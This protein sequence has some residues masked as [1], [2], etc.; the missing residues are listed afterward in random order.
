MGH[1]R[2]DEATLAVCSLAESVRFP[3]HAEPTQ[4]TPLWVAAE[5]QGLRT[6]SYFWVGSEA[7]IHGMRPSAFFPYNGTVTHAQRIE[8][9]L[10]WF[11][12]PEAS[13]PHL[14]TLYFSD[15][16]SAGH[17]FGAD[18]DEVKAA[19]HAA[20]ESIGRLM[21]GLTGVTP[22]PN[23]VI[24]AD[25]GMSTVSGVI[26]ITDDVDLSGFRVVNESTHL[27]IYSKDPA[28]V[29]AALESLNKKGRHYQA[30]RRE[31]VPAHLHFSRNAR[32]GDI[33]VIP[34][35]AQFVIA[36]TPEVR[37]PQGLPKGWH[38]WDVRAV[39]DM[40]GLFCA[41]GPGIRRIEKLEPGDIDNVDV[42]PMVLR[43][44][45]L[46]VPAD[47]DGSMNLAGRILK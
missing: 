9:V 10:E 4:G 18:S 19:V 3:F 39:P 1:I 2:G 38:G 20:D 14:V 32:I 16:D 44:L 35:G 21:D 30:Y 22:R 28:R 12:M 13:R 42:F 26:D 43:L 25:H 7:S 24:V 27:M 8:K 29:D 17:R 45:Q 37:L 31:D 15:V 33:V 11:R 40:R 41:A 5:Q 46:V 36:R 6:A 34:E 47:I 23:V